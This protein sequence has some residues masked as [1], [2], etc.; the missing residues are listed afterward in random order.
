MESHVFK[1]LLIIEGLVSFIGFCIFIFV[2]S[3]VSNQQR[4]LFLLASFYL[5]YNLIQIILKLIEKKPDNRVIK[6]SH[7]KIHVKN[8]KKLSY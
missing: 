2:F 3:Y 7:A 8:I 6:N 4:Y 1:L 5:A